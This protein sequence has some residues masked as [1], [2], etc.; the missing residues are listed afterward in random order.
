MATKTLIL[1]PILVD[2]PDETLVSLVP[3]EIS[4]NKAHTL[5]NEVVADDD[6]GYILFSAGGQ[7][8][9]YFDY[10]RPSNAINITGASIKIRC[11][12][13]SSQNVKTLDNSLTVSSTFTATQLSNITTDYVDYELVFSDL[14]SLISELDSTEETRFTL[15]SYISTG[16]KQSTVR[17]TQIYI[18]ISYECEADES[19]IY[20]KSNGMWEELTNVH[21]YTKTKNFWQPAFIDNLSKIQKYIYIED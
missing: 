19:K 16:T 20:L 17:I 18:E 8:N 6:S 15:T 13:E 10:I 7:I 5:L 4:I 3:S 12:L 1:R 2:S 14:S 11:K 21:Y 9:S